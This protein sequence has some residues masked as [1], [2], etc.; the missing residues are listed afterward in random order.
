RERLVRAVLRRLEARRDRPGA[1]VVAA[2]VYRYGLQARGVLRVVGDPEEAERQFVGGH[3]LDEDVVVLARREVAAAG[4][5]LADDRLGEVVVG[6]RVDARAE[7]VHLAVG[8]SGADLAPSRDA[9]LR[10]RRPD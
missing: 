9:P 6:A 4:P 1:V 8:P 7:Q 3:A 5:F 10:V 2:V